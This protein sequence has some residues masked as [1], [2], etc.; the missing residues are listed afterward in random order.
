MNLCEQILA[1]YKEALYRFET[2]SYKLNEGT[3]SAV[4]KELLQKEEALAHRTTQVAETF[5]R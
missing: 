1:S 2:G 3:V 5:A 4:K